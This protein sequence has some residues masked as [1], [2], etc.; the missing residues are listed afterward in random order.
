VSA[1]TRDE[2]VR[3]YEANYAPA[4]C[5]FGA[6]GDIGPGEASGI[7][8]RHFGSWDRKAAVQASLPPVP[9]T[10]TG[11]P[12][13]RMVAKDTAQSQIRIGHLGMARNSSGQYTAAV[14]SSVYGTGGFSSRLMQEVR[15]RKGYA[16]SVGG[17]F[18][19]D[20]PRGVFFA[21]ASSKT[22]TTGAALAAMIEVT[23]STARGVVTADE[24]RTAKRD[25]IQFFVT[26][27]DVPREVV[28]QRM[29]H[30]LQGYPAD[31]VDNFA[32]RVEAVT[33]A[34]LER[35]AREQIHPDRLR[36]LVVGD[37]A[38]MDMPLRVFGRVDTGSGEA[39]TGVAKGR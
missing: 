39:G 25:V 5:W 22:A 1:I 12:L 30:D 32:S 18:V 35:V 23:T 11:G 9:E 8:R 28:Y 14:L 33:A 31:Y 26:R 34:D 20:N 21:V 19:D 7:V 27:F 37:P 17:G 24:L 29:L 4:N 15:T 13:V 38:A 3:F 16:Y 36:I 10:T 6:A 2:V